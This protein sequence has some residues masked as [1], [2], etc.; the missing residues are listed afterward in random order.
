MEM[1]ARNKDNKSSQLMD[2]SDEIDRRLLQAAAIC[3]LAG[4]SESVQ[5]VELPT[6]TM[7][8]AMWAVRDLIEESRVLSSKMR[9]IAKGV[10]HGE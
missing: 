5:G 7:S 10:S 2:C 8:N 1:I 9:A 6:D 3:S 4:A